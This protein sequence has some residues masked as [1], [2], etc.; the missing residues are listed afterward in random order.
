M[1]EKINKISGDI[2]KK[3]GEYTDEYYKICN[4]YILSLLLHYITY[5]NFYREGYYKLYSQHWRNDWTLKKYIMIIERIKISTAI[6][7]GF[8]PNLGRVIII[9]LL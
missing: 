6:K 9:N 1:F 5:E 2:T 4:A 7:E 3:F 8:Y